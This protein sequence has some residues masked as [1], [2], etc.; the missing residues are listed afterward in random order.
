MSCQQTADHTTLSYCHDTAPAGE[1]KYLAYL[2]LTSMP[3]FETGTCIL[4]LVTFWRVH[5][6][7]VSSSWLFPSIW[8]TKLCK[9]IHALITILL[10]CRSKSMERCNNLH[11][12]HIIP[13]A[14]STCLLGLSSTYDILPYRV[15]DY[16]LSSAIFIASSSRHVDM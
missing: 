9:M 6:S 12:L 8:R 11:L 14:H 15:G 7:M 10:N 2:S 13:N 3:F 4:A 16:H 5:S 1:V